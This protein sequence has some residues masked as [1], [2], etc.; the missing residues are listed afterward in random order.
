MRSIDPTR[1]S[2][3]FLAANPGLLAAMAGRPPEGVTT[4]SWEKKAV[5]ADPGPRAARNR[6]PLELKFLRLWNGPELVEEYRFHP[7]RRWRADF[8]HLPTKTLIE[9]EG[10]GYRMGRHNRTVGFFQDS[11]KYLEAALLGFRV[12]RLASPQITSEIL[13]RVANAVRGWHQEVRQKNACGRTISMD[14]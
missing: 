6:S 2:K 4:K 14:L 13:D 5:E 12:I 10:G 1:V 8:A 3:S 9:V 7:K 11:E